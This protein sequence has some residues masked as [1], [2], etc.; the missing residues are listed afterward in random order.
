MPT[1]EYLCKKCNHQF[2]IEQK[3]TEDPLEKCPECSK[4]ALQRLIAGS[5]S[6]ILAGAGWY[7]DG[8]SGKNK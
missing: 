8:Y 6:F 2:E 7:R 5:S 4:K 1:Y 3:I